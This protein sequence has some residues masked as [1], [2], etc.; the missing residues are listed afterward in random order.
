MHEIRWN[1]TDSIPFKWLCRVAA[2]VV[3]VSAATS[4]A[5]T[6]PTPAPQQL[7]ET[8]DAEIVVTGQVQRGAVVGDIKPELQLSPADIRARV[9]YQMILPPKDHQ[10]RQ[11]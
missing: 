6:V 2:L 7:P 5:Q 1:L 4:F 3:G 8:E 11:R 10:R 9:A